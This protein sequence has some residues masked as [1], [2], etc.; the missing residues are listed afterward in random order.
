MVEIAA[1]GVTL[2]SGAIIRFSAHRL[3]SGSVATSF[4]DL[5]MVLAST[6]KLCPESSVPAMEGNRASCRLV[7]PS[8]S[9][10]SA[11]AVVLSTRVSVAGLA[12]SS[13]SVSAALRASSRSARSLV[14]RSADSIS[15]ERALSFASRS[16][17]W[18]MSFPKALP[19]SPVA[20]PAPLTMLV[21]FCTAPPLTS[22]A[23]EL[24]TDSTVDADAVESMPMVSP[25]F[26]R[27]ADE[28]TSAGGSR[29]EHIA[30]RCR[31]TQFGGAAHRDADAVHD[32]Q[33]GDRGVVAGL[34]RLQLPHIG[35]REFDLACA[36]RLSALANTA[37]TR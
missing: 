23:A 26:S 21:K 25:A 22:S 3:V 15:P 27:G 32:A 7:A 19:W 37:V 2:I 12:A 16:L 35:T 30:E 5:A 34:H 6:T 29:H 10:R 33:G 9:T 36:G 1:L 24:N 13:T 8:C 14:W 11:S 20:L 31:G 4:Q 18:P 28:S 17:D